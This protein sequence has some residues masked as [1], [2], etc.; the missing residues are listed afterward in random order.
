MPRAPPRP[1]R[2]RSP[3]PGDPTIARRPTIADVARAAG[4]SPATVDRVLNG[5][6]RVRP[7][8][9]ARV[10]EAAA[11]IGYHAAPLIAQRLSPD[12]PEIRLGFVLHKERQPFWQAV[13]AGLSAAAAAAPGV[14]ARAEIAFSPSQ[15]PADFARLIETLGAR[16]DA[17]AASAV[18]HPEVTDAVARL[19]DRG[20]P[21][22]AM[23][24][25]FAQGVRQGY[26]GLNNLKVGRIAA[27]ML[28]LAAPAR[29]RIA[30]FVG[31]HR[32]H[33][34]DLRETGL[35]SWFRECAPDFTL[36]ETRVNLET[37]QLTYE[38]TLDLLARHPDLCGIYCAGGG[39]EGA[40]AALREARP[41]AAVPLVVNE[42]T[43]DSRAALRDGYVTLVI[44][45]P[46]EELCR[47]LV[48]QMA[49]AAG[50]GA[51]AG[52][53]QH[54]LRPDLILPESL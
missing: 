19:R 38:A 15:T 35:R 2:P 11:R 8:T 31:G 40:I 14:R 27:S 37:R 18:S 21:T 7:E 10:A 20:I 6:E 13:A 28:A 51:P 39:M 34:H 45:T 36:L 41:P 46:L 54:F 33:G 22:F 23:L 43:P 1:T 48:A 16:V 25:D 32:W 30:V 4:L 24:N 3:P 50:Q 5:R 53:G 44:A 52:P 49:A 9:A 12:L 29:G 42:L 26:I 17:V 47:T